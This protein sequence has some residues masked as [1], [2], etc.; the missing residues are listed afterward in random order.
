MASKR[1]GPDASGVGAVP[2]HYPL[3]EA[4]TALHQPGR[5]SA[6]LLAHGSLELR[7]YA[8]RGTDPQVPHTRDEVYVVTSG[9]GWF[10][11]GEERVAFEPGDALFV[12][13]GVE[14]RFEDFSDDFG[15]W[16]LFYGPE[17]GERPTA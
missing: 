9:R 3:S 7:Y 16:V 10:V 13:A 17:G 6:L 2:A 5:A 15:T 12:A 14:H 1:T 11:R 4:R 8:P